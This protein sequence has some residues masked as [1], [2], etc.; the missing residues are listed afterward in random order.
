MKW[1]PISENHKTGGLIVVVHERAP[2]DAVCVR[3][4]GHQWVGAYIQDFGAIAY[5]DGGFTVEFTHACIL[6]DL[7]F[8]P[9]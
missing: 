8:R 7:P 6:P 4:S 3:W 2:D 9:A 5:S 1:E